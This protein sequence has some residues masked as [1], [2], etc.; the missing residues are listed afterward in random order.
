MS[1]EPKVVTLWDKETMNKAAQQHKYIFVAAG[2]KQKKYKLL[3]GAEKAWRPNKNKPVIPYVYLSDLR[4]MGLK[5][6]VVE[7]L[8]KNNFSEQDIKIHFKKAYTKEQH[9]EAYLQEL[10]A[11]KAYRKSLADSANEGIK[12][13][14][15]DLEWFISALKDCKEEPSHTLTKVSKVTPKSKRDL[16]L[17]QV[18][19]AKETNKII[20][21]STLETV[22]AKLR[23][24]PTKKGHK[25]FNQELNMETDNIKSYK[26]AIEWIYGS[27][28][29]YEDNIESVKS[30]LADKKRPGQKKVEPKT[31]VT[32]KK[33]QMGSPRK[34]L[35]PNKSPG[36]I[37]V[38]GGENFTSI[39]PLKK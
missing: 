1:T 18:Q 38:T 10:E 9:G 23:D 39:P 32:E 35:L 25:V 15:E 27:L 31:E 30:A 22:G 19:K 12:Y 17:E 29:G 8:K 4:L 14:L 16:F 5:D 2:Q 13:G 34:Q 3:T 20:D 24:Q 11:L 21:V 26:K 36:A 6:D 7:E 37:R 33:K 28:T